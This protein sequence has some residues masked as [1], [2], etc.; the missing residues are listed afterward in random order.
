MCVLTYTPATRGELANALLGGLLRPLYGVALATG[1]I[2]LSDVAIFTPF[3]LLVFV[4]PLETEWPDRG[5]D[6]ATSKRSLAVRLPAGR[7]R[8]RGRGSHGGTTA[9]DRGDLAADPPGEPGAGSAGHD[10]HAPG[11]A[12]RLGSPPG[13]LTTA[14]IERN[15]S[16][17]RACAGA[18]Y[19][20]PH[21]RGV[22]RLR[23]GRKARSGRPRI[24]ECVLSRTR[25]G[26]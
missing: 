2:S 11:S 5:A 9:I 24:G 13:P 26:M 15:R 4:N 10:R 6:G 1:R 8:A 22:E 19:A 7:V 25:R 21:I 23:L 20:N 3:T 17:R 14:L 12:A 16:S 18:A